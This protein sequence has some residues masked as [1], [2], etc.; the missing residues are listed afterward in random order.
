V[1]CEGRT[2]RLVLEGIPTRVEDES[3]TQG[4]I[5]LYPPTATPAFIKCG[6]NQSPTQ[7]ALFS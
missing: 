4:R 1:E 7:H 5:G 6:W 2:L 3:Q